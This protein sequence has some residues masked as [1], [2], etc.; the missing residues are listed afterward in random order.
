MPAAWSDIAIRIEQIRSKRGIRLITNC[1]G[2]LQ[3]SGNL[4][5]NSTSKAVIF[6]Q[7][8]DGFFRLFYFASDIASL[9]PL[10]GDME[11]RRDIVIGYLDKLKHSELCSTFLGKHFKEIAHYIRMSRN[12]FP[13]AFSSEE[14]EFAQPKELEQVMGLLRSTFNPMTDY[15]PSRELLD[16]LICTNHVIVRRE[17]NR[18]SGLVVF[19][20]SGKRVNFNYLLNNGP[21][22]DGMLLKQSFFKCMAERGISSGFL[23]VDTRN[24]P[25]LRIYEKTGWKPDGLNDWFFLR[26]RNN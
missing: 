14:P 24:A 13:A 12:S 3:D 16:Q 1:Y 15:L 11:E 2:P 10:L 5:M 23:W 21:K 17:A 20:I 8:E 19:Q 7:P 6:L 4:R 26:S 18:I 9:E 22:G 25:A